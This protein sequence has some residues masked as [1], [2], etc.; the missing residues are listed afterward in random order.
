MNE[1]DAPTVEIESQGRGRFLVSGALTFSTVTRALEVS[2]RLFSNGDDALD[3]DLAG[4]EAADSAGL[5]LLVEWMS[6]ARR[7]KRRL[8]FYNVPKQLVAIA[9]ISEIDQLLP[10]HL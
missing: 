2:E 9:K 5:A 4:V 8:E 3:V 10:I 1:G 6:R 7:E